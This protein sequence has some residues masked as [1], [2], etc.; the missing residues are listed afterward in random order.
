MSNTNTPLHLAVQNGNIAIVEMLLDAGHDLNA[1][2]ADGPTPHQL[3]VQLGHTKIVTLLAEKNKGT[4]ETPSWTVPDWTVQNYMVGVLLAII[5]ISIYRA[6]TTPEPSYTWDPA[7]SRPFTHEMQEGERNKLLNQRRGTPR[8]TEPSDNEV[9]K[10]AF[11]PPA[12]SLY[13]RSP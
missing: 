4:K 7:P 11:P 6:Y 1:V 12:E 10:V 5:F 8:V 3:A 13:L 2:N 9:E